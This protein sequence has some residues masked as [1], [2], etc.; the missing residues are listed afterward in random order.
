MEIGS[1]QHKQEYFQR[2]LRE[3]QE[4]IFFGEFEIWTLQQSVDKLQADKKEAEA[5]LE[6]KEFPTAGEG[7]KAIKEL[8]EQI[9]EFLM[10]QVK[11]EGQNKTL[12]NHL[13]E[14]GEFIKSFVEK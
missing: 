6:R 3:M 7:R 2:L 12:A 5:K 1:Q 8:N 11:I 13:I 14:T 10:K 4:S 9:N